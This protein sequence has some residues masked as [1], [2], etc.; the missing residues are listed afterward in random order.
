MNQANSQPQTSHINYVEFAANNLALI[1]T[2]YVSTF[3]W[4]FTDYGDQYIAFENA[5]LHGGFYLSKHSNNAD[6]GGAL[7][8]LQSNDLEHSK[9][10]IIANGGSIKTD[11][12]SFPGGKRFHFLD[13]CNNELAVW[14]ID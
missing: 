8:V 10:Q 2:F 7:V 3:N 11:I 4:Q 12:F 5:G 9:A 1:K 13:P 14:C 6:I